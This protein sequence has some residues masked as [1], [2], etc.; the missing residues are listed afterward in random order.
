M[1]LKELEPTKLVEHFR[2][3]NKE[4][5][6]E[7]DRK[8]LFQKT[9]N[10]EDSII[11]NT[12][13]NEEGKTQHSPEKDFELFKTH[14]LTSRPIDSFFVTNS[15]Y[16]DQ[17][18]ECF[19]DVF[20]IKLLTSSQFQYWK[21]HFPISYFK[22][23]KVA[24]SALIVIFCKH[25]M[26]NFHQNEYLTQYFSLLRSK[27][28]LDIN[29][30][31]DLLPHIT[32]S[33][34][35]NTDKLAF[36]QFLIFHFPKM[37]IKFNP[38]LDI[39]LSNVQLLDKKTN[40]KLSLT[41][42]YP[43]INNMLK[44]E[45]KLVACFADLLQNKCTSSEHLRNFIIVLD[46]I[47]S[48]FGDRNVSHH[49]RYLNYI[50]NQT[51]VT[52]TVIS[53]L[54]GLFQGNKVFKQSLLDYEQDKNSVNSSF[55]NLN[56]LTD[57]SLVYMNKAEPVLEVGLNNSAYPFEFARR[58]ERLFDICKQDKDQDYGKEFTVKEKINEFSQFVRKVE[59]LYGKDFKNKYENTAKKS[60]IRNH[61][62]TLKL[63]KLSKM[64]F[65]T[66]RDKIEEYQNLFNQLEKSDKKY[67][68][69]SEA[70]KQFNDFRAKA[71]NKAMNSNEKEK[72]DEDAPWF[73]DYF[74]SVH[75]QSIRQS[76]INS[77]FEYRPEKAPEPP[78]YDKP[79]PRR[80]PKDKRPFHQQI[81]DPFMQKEDEEF[82]EMMDQLQR[83]ADANKQANYLQYL[84]QDNVWFSEKVEE[85]TPYVHQMAQMDE[86]G[87]KKELFRTNF[88]LIKSVIREEEG[89][90]AEEK[91]KVLENEAKKAGYKV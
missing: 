46:S 38:L 62:N 53:L 12:M 91:L 19:D 69:M 44:N 78:I 28:N 20:L 13:L 81:M 63:H 32:Q 4:L 1:S 10:R 41:M 65:S 67:K 33:T 71:G 73:F 74:F 51:G 89:D 55:K 57:I 23:C 47:E 27:Q 29:S 49:L 25:L 87:I 83:Q 88:E 22:D 80:P 6:T 84:Y 52:D 70:E 76:I 64:N 58:V 15:I 17:F 26:K 35:H 36:Y 45:P 43:A 16:S 3:V 39:I 18:K 72:F 31:K 30:V 59:E 56:H 2:N 40:K 82:N 75:L 50:N 14:I 79:K 24:N 21:D 37:F 48:L 5:Q 60:F 8:D 9:F 34:A 68:Q 85:M 86:E 7:F 77:R 54:K 42:R 11:Y 66:N 90:A 61:S